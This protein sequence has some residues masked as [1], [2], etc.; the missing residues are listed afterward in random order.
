MPSES[1]IFCRNLGY[2]GY[3]FGRMV[4][5]H[6]RD[7]CSVGFQINRTGIL[8]LRDS[9]YPSLT[10]ECSRNIWT[11][12]GSTCERAVA[13][14]WPPRARVQYVASRI[15]F[16]AEKIKLMSFLKICLRGRSHFPA[17]SLLLVVSDTCSGRDVAPFCTF[18]CILLFV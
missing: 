14:N 16:A 10:V 9:I 18:Q 1:Y 3:I 6:Y 2:I 11:A 15:R 7:L 13:P 8:V 4:E 5:I 12:L 17:S